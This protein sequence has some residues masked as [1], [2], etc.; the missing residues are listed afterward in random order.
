MPSMICYLVMGWS[1]VAKASILP[2]FLSQ[3]GIDLL[4]YGGVSYTIGAVF[5]AFG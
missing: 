2:Q 5:Y 1:I 3:Q 4:L